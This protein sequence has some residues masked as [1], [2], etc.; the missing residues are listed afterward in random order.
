MARP[1]PSPDPDEPPH[2]GAGTGPPGAKSARWPSTIAPRR[3]VSSSLVADAHA[4]QA[5]RVR[6]ARRAGR[7]LAR[8]RCS[9]SSSRP[10][11]RSGLDPVVGALV[12]RGWGRGRA[13]LVVFAALFAAVVADP[14]RHRRAAV[15]RRSWTSSTSCRATGTSSRRATRSRTLTSTRRRRHGRNGAQGPRRGPPGRRDAL[16]GSPAGSSARVLSLVTLTFLALFLL[17]ERPTITDWL[18]GFAPP[19]ARR[20]GARWWRTRSAPSPPR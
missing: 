2:R 7:R 13:A 15:G 17:M 8:R 16:L 4:A 3:A 14:A 5:A 20:A 19:E 6:R 11:S 9:R 18:F 10:C 1:T 12:R